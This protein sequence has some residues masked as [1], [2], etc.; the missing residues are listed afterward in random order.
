MYLIFNK[1]TQTGTSVVF[2]L[3]IAFEGARVLFS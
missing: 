1:N 3:P 2:V